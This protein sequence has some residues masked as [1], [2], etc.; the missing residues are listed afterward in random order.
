MPDGTRAE[1]LP[2]TR[3]ASEFLDAFGRPPRQVT[4][5]CERNSEPSVAQALH[6]I[7]AR[8]LNEKVAAKGGVLDRLLAASLS[9]QAVLE[10]ITLACLCRPPTPVESRLVMAAIT[11]A[12]A[13]SPGRSALSGSGARRKRPYCGR[14]GRAGQPR[15][16]EAGLRR[17]ALGANEWAGVSVQSLTKT[18]DGFDTVLKNTKDA[19]PANRLNYNNP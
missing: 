10:E 5:E 14:K 16:P 1:S 6:F 19:G 12:L 11:A 17:H 18:C 8:T 7:N 4:C 3:V 15:A 2:D 13:A 9:D